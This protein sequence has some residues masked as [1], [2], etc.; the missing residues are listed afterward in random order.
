MAILGID[1]G[2]SGIKGAMVDL[3]SGEFTTP[4]HRIA[5]PEG[6]LPAD[7]AVVVKEMVKHFNYQ[8]PVGCGFPAVVRDGVVYTAA[9][10]D[11]SWIGVNANKLFS[12]STGCPVYIVNDADAAGIAEMTFGVGKDYQ[13]GIVLL[14]TLGT[15]IGSAVFVN[16][17]LLPNTEL[18][19]IEIRGKD[20]EQRASA[21]VRTKKKLSWKAWTARLQEYLSKIE[22][23]LSPDVI[24]IGGGISKDSEKYFPLL[25]TRAKMIPASLLNQAGIVGAALYAHE[26]GAEKQ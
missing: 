20:A 6:A 16:G 9:N 17:H 10:I 5:T 3:E 12:E 8:G 23:L 4:R 21:A 25:K 26:K 24:I 2:G 7:V 14:L 13:E 11:H 1:I 19:H 18:G 15:G 22:M